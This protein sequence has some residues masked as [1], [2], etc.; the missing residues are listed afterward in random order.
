MFEKADLGINFIPQVGNHEAFPVNEFDYMTERE[1]SF[2]VEFANMWRGWL[3]EETA[4][5]F[6]YNGYYKKEFNN[7]KVI[8]FDS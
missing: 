5:F 8:A 6:K 2:R 1:N 7:F 3:G 4:E